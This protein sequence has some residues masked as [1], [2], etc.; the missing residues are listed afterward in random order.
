MKIY[1][2]ILNS[3][4]LSG[5]YSEKILDHAKQSATDTL[6][7]TSK[8]AIQKTAEK[9]GDLIV[10]KVAYSVKIDKYGYLTGEEI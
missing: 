8:R 5:K 3:K 2:T 6:K 1:K 4:N 9:T 7:T 10:N